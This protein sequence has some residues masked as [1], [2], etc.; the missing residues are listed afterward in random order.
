[1][2]M[3]TPLQTPRLHLRA[4]R[5]ED[6]PAL[7]DIF[8]RDEVSEYYDLD[9]FTELAEA[10]QL[11]RVWLRRTEAGEGL[12]WA[13]TR[14]G[15]DRLIGTCGLHQY[16]PSH[17]RAEIGYELHPDCWGQG[18]MTEAV[19][20]LLAY[21]FGPLALHRMEAFIDPANHASER[22]L[23]RC[24]LRNEGILRDY[25]FEK[26]RFVNAQMMAILE[27]D[28]AALATPR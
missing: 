20:A 25:F 11:V 17:R 13:L 3:F 5:A 1:M 6:A 24:G 8:S 22:L 27:Q 4:L 7:L 21:G 9:T 26:G 18:L 2:L 14:S 23:E 12:R 19:Q 15:D 10:E 28:Y 16:C